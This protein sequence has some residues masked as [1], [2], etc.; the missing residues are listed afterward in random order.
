MVVWADALLLLY[1][2]SLHNSRLRCDF[3]DADAI[4]QGTKCVGRGF[5]N[6]SYSFP[7]SDI[8]YLPYR[9]LRPACEMFHSAKC[10]EWYFEV[11]F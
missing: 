3:I 8:S 6:L 9:Q 7:C 10:V 4:L 2:D 1:Y 5:D 11:M